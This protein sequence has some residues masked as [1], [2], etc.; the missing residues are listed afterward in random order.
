MLGKKK[1]L[2]LWSSFAAVL[3]V[4]GG[5]ALWYQPA[6]EASE[7]E[8]TMYQSVTCSCC[9][10][11]ATH[12]RKAGF[13]VIAQ[14]RTDMSAIKEEYGVMS[15]LRSCHTAIVDGYVIEGHVPA[16]DIKMLLQEKPAVTGLTAPGMPQKSPGMQPEGMPPKDYR[17]LSFDGKGRTSVVTEY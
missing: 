14:N 15:S 4:A 7:V 3:S 12:L 8:I 9:K 17:V 13:S 5:A 6:L 10:H 16:A 11:W 2:R 1:K